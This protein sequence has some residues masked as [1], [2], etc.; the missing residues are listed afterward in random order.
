ML[1]E[2]DENKILYQKGIEI[3]GLGRPPNN[4]YFSFGPREFEL[5][6][7]EAVKGYTRYRGA[8]STK[9]ANKYLVPLSPCN[10]HQNR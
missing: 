4:S 5:K 8:S 10:Q 2:K 7:G 6:A 9:K 1:Y 3:S